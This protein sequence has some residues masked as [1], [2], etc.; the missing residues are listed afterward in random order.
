V[1][2]CLT[3][4]R[5]MGFYVMRLCLVCVKVVCLACSCELVKSQV[6]TLVV[7][8]S[9]SEELEKRLRYDMYLMRLRPKTGC[10]DITVGLFQI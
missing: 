10:H 1:A 7:L 8:L 3:E 4:G 6:Q 2:L 5:V 9:M